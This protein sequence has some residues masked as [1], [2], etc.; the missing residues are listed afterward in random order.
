MFYSYDQGA[1]NGIGQL[2]QSAR[3]GVSV[4]AYT[5][6]RCVRG[7]VAESAD[8]GLRCGEPGERGG[9]RAVGTAEEL[10]GAAELCATGESAG[11][12][13][14]NAV[15]RSVQYDNR[16]RPSVLADSLNGS[17]SSYLFQENPISWYANSN[18]SAITLYEGGP[19]AVGSLT[20]FAQ[21]FTYTALNQLAQMKDSGGGANNQRNFSYDQYGNL[22]MANTS[23]SFPQ[24]VITPS[25]NVYNG[26]NQS[27]ADT[28]DA[29]GNNTGIVS[30]CPNCIGYDAEN[31]EVSFSATGTSYGYDGNG[32]RV[33]KT[34]GGVSTVYVYDAAGALAA[35]YS[36]ATV[37]SSPCTTC[38]VSVDHLGSVRMVT[39]QSGTVVGRHDYLAFGE[40]I[41][42]GYAGRTNAGLWGASD[43]ADQRFTGQVRDVETGLDYFNARY[44]E[45]PIGRFMSPDPGNAG[46]DATNPQTWNAYVYGVNSPLS[47]TD[48]SGLNWF[49]DFFANL[50]S[51][52]L[53]PDP[54]EGNCAADFCATGTASAPVETSSAGVV[55]G[56]GGGSSGGSG[57]SGSGVA[58]FSTTVSL[59]SGGSPVSNSVSSVPGR[60]GT[61]DSGVVG[62][63]VSKY[64]GSNT[65]L[66]GTITSNTPTIALVAA[67]GSLAGPPGEFAGA[68]IGSMFGVGGSVSYVPGTGSLYAGPVAAFGVGVN[69]GSG[70]SVS[71]VHVPSS[72]NANSI[73]NGKSFSL[74]YQPNPFLGS[75]VTKSPGSGPPVVGPSLGTRVP[76]SASAGYGFCLRHCGC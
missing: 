27:S 73:A 34:G 49:T 24:S 43:N 6:F 53:G 5:A 61:C 38:Y 59:Q 21:S 10:C 54:S 17:S 28:Y 74:T 25:T 42:A 71:A 18:V 58:Q 2:T 16:L 8:D 23:G 12:Q 7:C 30:I 46:T 11:L 19:G 66:S 60:N 13:Y 1:I 57:G 64:I 67:I 33:L 48:P 22:W 4:T 72:Q 26:F 70:F 51:F 44:Y 56:F 3:Q 50:G 15:T 9:G 76:V 20:K 32:Q 41:G 65:I 36:S 37:G 29:A 14:G 39:D 45:S 68:L 52:L 35:E 31:L 63:F 69:G 62:Q 47:G 40:E 75:S 55:S